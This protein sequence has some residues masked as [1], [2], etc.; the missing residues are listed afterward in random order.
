MMNNKFS[1]FVKKAKVSVLSKLIGFFLLV[2]IVVLIALATKLII[3]I[4]CFFVLIGI[5]FYITTNKERKQ[6][7]KYRLGIDVNNNIYIPLVL[8]SDYLK[9]VSS[10]FNNSVEMSN[11][12]DN[13]V[14]YVQ[15]MIDNNQM[16]FVQKKFKLDDIV[17][18]LNNLL[19]H[20]NINYTI[21][22]NDIIK[23]DDEIVS[24][25]RKDNI[26]NDLHDLAIIRSILEKNQL[27]LITFFAPNEGFSKLAKI[28]G[29][30]LAV[31]PINKLET[32][33]KYQIE[34]ANKL[35]NR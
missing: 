19:Q 14:S 15:Y 12:I 4:P 28:D 10:E 22:K 30:V 17:N 21:D 13:L 34:L 33:K 1:D 29:Y 6:V 32:L 8:D 27:E 16:I 5:V 24:L 11:N 2:I 26:I 23:I 35:N 3:V 18:L 7:V 31:I 20:Q 25:R 9:K